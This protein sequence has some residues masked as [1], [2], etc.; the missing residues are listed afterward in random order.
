MKRAAR[1]VEMHKISLHFSP[2]TTLLLRYNA[3]GQ[4]IFAGIH[5]KI[6]TH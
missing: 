4:L 3:L 1:W 2:L 5:T 6:K